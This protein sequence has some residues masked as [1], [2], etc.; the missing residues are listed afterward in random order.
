MPSPS[1][2]RS[3]RPGERPPSGPPAAHAPLEGKAGSHAPQPV[4]LGSESAAGEEDPG[5]GLDVSP[6][7]PASGAFPGAASPAVPEE[8]ARAGGA[9]PATA[10]VPGPAG[11]AGT[12]PRDPGRV[13][14]LDPLEAAHWC[15]EFGCTEAQL[16]AL[17]GRVGD[18]AA[19]VREAIE[20]GALADA[21]ARA[22][23]PGRQA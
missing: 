16:Q 23:M 22:G 8:A 9:T 7:G 13:N 10:S 20:Q 17:V 15:E 11:H 4:D 14:L 18:H 5:A 2:P 19:A 21:G 3:P 1:T 6:V 12:V